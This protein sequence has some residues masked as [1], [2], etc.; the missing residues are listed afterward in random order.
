LVDPLLLC[1][2]LDNI[3]YHTDGFQTSPLSRCFSQCSSAMTMAKVFNWG[4]AYTFRGLL[5][6][7]SGGEHGGKQADMMSEKE[8][9]VL[10]LDPQTAGRGK[11]WAWLE[12]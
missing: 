11:D 12:F 3:W 4:L 9:R 2:D 5:H 1:L 6:C 10:P 7:P 8:L